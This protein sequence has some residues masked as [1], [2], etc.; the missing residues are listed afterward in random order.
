MLPQQRSVF[1]CFSDYLAA[2][3]W[4]LRRARIVIMSDA[5]DRPAL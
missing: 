3:A 5:E 2:A 1:S 4:F